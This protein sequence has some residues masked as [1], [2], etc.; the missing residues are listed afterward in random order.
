M[1]AKIPTDDCLQSP[2]N[3]AVYRY[4]RSEIQFEINLINARVNWLIAS[5]AFLFVSLAAGAQGSSAA[6]SMFFPFVPHLGI[7]LC[8]F[9]LVAISA[10]VWRSHLASEVR[11][12]RLLRDR[13]KRQVFHCHPTH[14]AHPADGSR[15]GA[16]SP[17]GSR[18]GL[19]LRS[20]L[21]AG[22]RGLT[23]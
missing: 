18:R 8:V 10:A 9:V 16:W 17:G 22:G 14:S 5:Q 11:A 23:G 6:S 13:R 2:N 1:S 21:A 20:P 15:R 19:G 7:V 4:I 12:G 3:D